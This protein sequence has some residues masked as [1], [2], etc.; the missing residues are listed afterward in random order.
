M[1][2]FVFVYLRKH[3]TINWVKLRTFISPKPSSARKSPF[4]LDPSQAKLGNCKLVRAQAEKSLDF[5]FVFKPSQPS[6][7]G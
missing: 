4:L 5:Y 6:L 1:I 2:L 3:L 7:I